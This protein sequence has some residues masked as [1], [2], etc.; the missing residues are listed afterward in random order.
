MDC[1]RLSTVEVEESHPAKLDI[2]SEIQKLSGLT[3]QA[4]K[5]VVNV[6]VTNNGSYAY[7]DVIEV[8]L[9]KELEDNSGTQ[10]DLQKQEILLEPSAKT[11][12]KFTFDNLED[13]AGYFYYIYYYSTENSQNKRYRVS[14]YPAG[15]LFH[16]KYTPDA[17]PGDSNGD[18][19]VNAADI[20]EVV[21]FIMGNQSGGFNEAAADA[22]GDGLVNAADIVAIVNMIM[23]N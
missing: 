15:Y 11:S 6:N 21:N 22:N 3:I 8:R 2:S 19:T 23:G 5:M 17:T 7:D 10:V 16:F 9:Y 1:N 20:V 13:G 12:L 4:E 14:N 18:G